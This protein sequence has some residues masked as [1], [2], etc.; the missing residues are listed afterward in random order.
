MVDILELALAARRES[1]RVAF[2]IL[3]SDFDWNQIV[4]DIAA[5]ANSGGGAIVIRDGPL[6]P[7]SR[8]PLPASGERV[9]EGRV[10]G[11]ASAADLLDALDRKSVV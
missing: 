9:S 10:R 1:R 8:V 5:M 2:R 3:T 11:A 7:A 6:T 4:K